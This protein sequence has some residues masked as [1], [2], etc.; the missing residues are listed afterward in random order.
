MGLLLQQKRDGGCF[1]CQLT[2]L[3]FCSGYNNQ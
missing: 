2:Q 1:V 3:S